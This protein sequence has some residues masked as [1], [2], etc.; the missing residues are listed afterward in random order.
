MIDLAAVRRLRHQRPGRA[1][2]PP[3]PHGQ[4]LQR[5][6]RT[7]GVHAAARLRT[8]ASAPTSRS[9]AS[10]TERSGWS[11]A[12]STVPRDAALVPHA[13]ARR[14]LGHVRRQTRRV[15]HDRRVGPERPALVESVTRRRSHERGVPVRLDARSAD[16]LDHR[17]LFRISYVGEHGWEIYYRD[18]TRSAIWDRSGKRAR[19]SAWC[20]SALGVYGTTGR[21]EKG[22]RLMGAELDGEYTP[23]EAGLARPKVKAADFIGKARLPRGSRRRAGRRCC[24]RSRSRITPRRR[25][26]RSLH[27]RRQRA[28]PHARRRADRR[29]E[30]PAVGGHLRRARVRRSGSTCCSRTC[31][32]STR[33]SA[34]SCASCT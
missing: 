16:R 11:P 26:H 15:L 25:R 33:S 5:R 1:R 14:R 29:R 34:P 30:G 6:G 31:R 9:C 2:L 3:A 19:R 4:Q 23:V 32:Q 18:G 24:A 21:L 27:D 7:L 10:A 12:R 20:R 13:P 8:A 28:D 22:Y 17:R